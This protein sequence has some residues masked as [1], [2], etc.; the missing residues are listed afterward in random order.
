MF[1]LQNLGEE[2]DPFFLT[3]N[4][5]VTPKMTLFK[6]TS[7]HPLPSVSAWK[8]SQELNNIQGKR[9]LWFC[10]SYQGSA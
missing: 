10:G 1:S 6:W 9:G 4:P 2:H 3:F 5:E 7:G 8:A